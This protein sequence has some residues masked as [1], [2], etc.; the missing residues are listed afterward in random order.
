M[1]YTLITAQGKV[2]P[3]FILAVAETYKL[4]FGG[5]IFTADV[6]QQPDPLTVQVSCTLG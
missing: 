3:F 1:K 5:V 2:M 4:A 6:L